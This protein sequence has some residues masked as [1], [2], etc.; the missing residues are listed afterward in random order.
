M[1]EQETALLRDTAAQ[2]KELRGSVARIERALF[3]VPPGSPDDEKPL[4]EGIRIVW[5]A[6][7]RGSWVARAVVYAIPT[8]AAVGLAAGQIKEWF[9]K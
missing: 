8:I 1:T 3:D 6:F 2:V 7:Q 4:I 5:R 9:G